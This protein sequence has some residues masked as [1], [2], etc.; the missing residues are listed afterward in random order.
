MIYIIKISWAKRSFLL[1]EK[2]YMQ[3]V[4]FGGQKLFWKLL[5]RYFFK[6]YQ[7]LLCSKKAKKNLTQSKEL[8]I[9]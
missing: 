1:L 5:Q 6:K 4:L 8:S 9:I 7:V 2:F 3:K